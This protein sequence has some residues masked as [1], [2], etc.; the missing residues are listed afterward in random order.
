MHQ[1]PDAL[2][3]PLP[4]SKPFL[5]WTGGK[6]RLLHELATRLPG[7]KR[8]I[9][10][11]V[12]AGSVFLGLPFER[13]VINDAN[14]DLMAI[15]AALQTRPQEFIARAAALFTED[16]RSTEAYLRLRAQFNGET[17]R[18]ERAVL[19]PYL[20]RHGFNGL[21]R[22]NSS[23]GF[24][25]PYGK[26]SKLPCFPREEM[27]AAHLKLQRTTLLSGGFAYAMEQAGVDDVLYC[28]PPYLDSTNG[29]SF[30]GYNSTRFTVTDH[31]RLRDLG[32][33]A[34]GRGATVVI[35]NHD[36]PAARELYRGWHLESVSVR[37]SISASAN[38]RGQ[39]Q[40]LIATM[41]WPGDTAPSFICR[42]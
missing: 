3:Q 2:S 37:R 24:N 1:H 10:P 40:E 16:N 22:V 36:T 11:F 32:L 19:L 23:G 31:E 21:F 35:S 34:A 12:G 28:D 13:Y 30:V 38:A 26:L 15:W 4:S 42:R 25:V 29:T 14:A 33:E 6:Q 27:E 9:E 18:F 8:L 20:N 7:R 5:R 17:D 41:P 39:V